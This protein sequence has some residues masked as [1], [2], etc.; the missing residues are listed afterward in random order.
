MT[1]DTF[2]DLISFFKNTLSK[3]RGRNRRIYAAELSLEIGRG[4]ISMVSEALS[5]A[6]DTIRKGIFEIKNDIVIEDAFDLRH[7]KKIE[8]HLPNLLVDIIAICDAQSQTDP[9]FNSTRLYTRLSVPQIRKQLIE[10]KG[11][12]EEELPTNQTL[13]TKIN[14]L[15]YGLKKIQK[16]K[17]LKKIEETDAIF[18]ELHKVNENAD[19]DPTKLRISLDT[20]NKVQIGDFSRGGVNRLEIKALDHDFGGETIVPFGI[21]TPQTDEVD[22][23]FSETKVTADFIVDCIEEYWEKNKHRYPNVKTLVINQDNGPESSSSRTQLIVR[24]VEF[25]IA[26]NIEIKL[27]YYPP[28]HSKYNPIERVWGILENHWNGDL[29]DSKDTVL[30]FA[31]TMTWKGNN[32]VVTFVTKVYESGITLP[33]KAMKVYESA[34]VRLAGQKNSL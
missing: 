7:R 33:K 27:A 6:R 18:E 5:M 25:S 34:I 10:Q 22:L 13:N 1:K 30:K 17:P 21:L 4:G 8:E 31:E 11:Y 16:T 19:A 24:L 26:N 29:L 23:Y 3:L 32:P 2:L 28:Y 15:G 12:T 9:S 20:K 14:S